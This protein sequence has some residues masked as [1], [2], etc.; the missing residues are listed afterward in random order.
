MKAFV[1]I[2]SIENVLSQF[3][4]LQHKIS[5]EEWSKI[6][7]HSHEKGKNESLSIRLQLLGLCELAG[8][9]TEDF[10]VHYLSSGKPV[11]K[12]S[13][14][15]MSWSHTKGVAA[16]VIAE[17]PIGIDVESDRQIHS[18]LYRKALHPLEIDA[19]VQL[20][21]YQQ[22]EVFLKKWVIKE[23]YLKMAG[24]TIA[25]HIQSVIVHETGS[26]VEY[27]R[28]NGIKTANKHIWHRFNDQDWYHVA[29][30]SEQKV[31]FTFF[32][33]FKTQL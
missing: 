11:L 8:I 23:A 20:N 18:G 21:E 16:T 10:P 28:P 3:G 25:H 17:C 33:A 4:H 24:L 6:T 31:D 19:L 5:E 9:T 32:G 15:F 13:E 30:V 1:H 14:W 2:N 26:H 12:R 22:K 7:R 27:I 29:L